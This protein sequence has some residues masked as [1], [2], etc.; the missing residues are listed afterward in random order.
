[1]RLIA[2]TRRE[3]AKCAHCGWPIDWDSACQEIDG[4][5]KNE[6][7][8]IARGAQR[9]PQNPTTLANA[10]GSNW[11]DA[12]LNLAQRTVWDFHLWRNVFGQGKPLATNW[13]QQ[14]TPNEVASLAEIPSADYQRALAGLRR[15][16]L[17]A[18][19]PKRSRSTS[20]R[21]RRAGVR[22]ASP[23]GA[24]VPR[25]HLP[26]PARTRTRGK[27]PKNSYTVAEAARISGANTGQ[28]SRAVNNG[29]LKSNGK[30]GR[31]RRIDALD[32]ARWMHERASRPER[33]ESV[34]AVRKKL[35]R[36][37]G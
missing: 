28:I 31:K 7:S 25:R 32:L 1:M 17:L 34:V 19:K 16:A 24:G 36:A 15:E 30:A 9:L 10:G 27:S 14:L 4:Q 5:L 20:T 2:Q 26:Q 37:E 8:L 13:Q 33:A 12:V 6:E 22:K 21:R 35:Q 29:K 18:Q 11:H 3:I 23:P